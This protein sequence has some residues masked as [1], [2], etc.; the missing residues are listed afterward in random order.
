M[1]LPSTIGLWRPWAA[2]AGLSVLLFLEWWRPFQ[3]PVQFKL[4]HLTTN[5]AIAGSNAVVINVLFGG[6][7][8]AWSQ[9]A[10]TEGWGL[11]HHLE[12][13]FFANTIAAVI[14]LDLLFYGVHWANHQVPVLWRCHR[15]HHSDLDLDVTSALR[16]HLGEILISTGI[17]TITIPILGISAAGLVIF[18]VALLAS[19]QFQHSN[20]RLPEPWETQLRRLIVTPHM[21][22]LH[23]SHCPQDHNANYGTI[24]STWDRVFGTYQMRI[25]RTEIQIGLDEYSLVKH[26]QLFRFYVMPFGRACRPAPIGE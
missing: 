6:V 21:H 7:L 26:V 24:F 4:R 18:E 12:L 14:L 22:W 1:D 13:G 25:P 20:I 11:L 9:R 5:L 19:A 8:V 23:H 3:V 16:F 15:A 17:K 2:V 10:D